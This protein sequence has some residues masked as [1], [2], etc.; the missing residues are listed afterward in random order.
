LLKGIGMLYAGPALLTTT[1][2]K[3]IGTKEEGTQ[4]LKEHALNESRLIC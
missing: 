3:S 1:R 4:L 2:L